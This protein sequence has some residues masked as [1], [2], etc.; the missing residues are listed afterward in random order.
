MADNAL[1][2]N[3]EDKQALAVSIADIV[4]RRIP[5]IEPYFVSRAD[6][7]VMLGNGYN[8]SLTDEVIKDPI[9]QSPTNFLPK[10]NAVGREQ[11]LSSSS[12]SVSKKPLVNYLRG[13]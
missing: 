4:V 13:K 11:K 8:S 12:N 3:D 9:F 1:H 5:R 10:E 2:L 6:I 7:D